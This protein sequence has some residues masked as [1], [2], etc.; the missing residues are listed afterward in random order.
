MRRA[1]V[2]VARRQRAE[3]SE[4]RKPRNDA[5]KKLIASRRSSVMIEGGI[6]V[7]MHS[8]RQRDNSVI[9]KDPCQNPT[10]QT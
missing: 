3:T 7:K 4:E 1:L 5:L 6:L 2:P 8:W 10:N 9:S